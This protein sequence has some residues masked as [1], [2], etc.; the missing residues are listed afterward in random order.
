MEAPPMEELL[1][2]AQPALNVATD[3]LLDLVEHV[4][5]RNCE[6]GDSNSRRTVETPSVVPSPLPCLADTSMTRGFSLLL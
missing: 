3:R 1:K 6:K 2:C 5:D 4:I